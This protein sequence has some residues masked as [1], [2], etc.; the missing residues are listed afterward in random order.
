MQQKVPA[1]VL[2]LSLDNDNG[3]AL[4]VVIVVVSLL[5]IIGYSALTRNVMEI[6]VTTNYQD[7]IQALHAAEAGVERVYAGFSFADTNGDGIVSA[8]D[9]A[10]SNNDIDGNGTIDFTQVFSNGTNIAA[11]NNRIQVN[12]N[13]TRAFVW[14][15]ASAAPDRVTIYSEGNPSGTNSK[16]E[17]SLSVSVGMSGLDVIYGALDNST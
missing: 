17:I 13:A 4:T 11:S 14:V 9:A 16:R 15:D 8:S 7:S 12:S 1:K 3:V 6:K 10:N 2:T 5:L